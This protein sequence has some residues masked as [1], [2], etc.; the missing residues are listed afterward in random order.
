MVRAAHNVANTVYSEENL[1]QLRD[2]QHDPGEQAAHLLHAVFMV[3]LNESETHGRVWVAAHA[4][5]HYLAAV[6]EGSG[7]LLLRHLRC[8]G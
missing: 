8:P 3:E 1:S 5:V 7:Q 4:A 2:M 6:L